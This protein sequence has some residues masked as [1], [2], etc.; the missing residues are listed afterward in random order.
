MGNR[1]KEQQALYKRRNPFYIAKKS[2]IRICNSFATQQR[3]LLDQIQQRMSAKESQH[4]ATFRD[5]SSIDGT[6]AEQTSRPFLRTTLRDTPKSGKSVKI[7]QK[8]ESESGLQ[9]DKR[10]FKR[11]DM[12]HKE[13]AATGGQEQQNYRTPSPIDS[14]DDLQLNAPLPKTSVTNVE[15][16]SELLFSYEHLDYIIQDSILYTRLTEF[17]ARYQPNLIPIVLHHMEIRKATKALE[18]ANAVAG[19]LGSFP[20][21]SGSQPIQAAAAMNK[22]LEERRQRVIDILMSEALPAQ[23]NFSLIDVVT[24]AM[25]KAIRGAQHT[26]IMRNLIGGLSEVFTLTDPSIEDNPIIYASEGAYYFDF[27]CSPYYLTN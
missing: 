26:A 5:K 16:L 11:K 6:T 8:E 7:A 1:S 21:D 17:L 2:L 15:G 18:Y 14:D 19:S 13:Q 20:G 23:I 4:E 10:N 22:D 27:D 3:R 9:K 25:Q 12:Q 24:N